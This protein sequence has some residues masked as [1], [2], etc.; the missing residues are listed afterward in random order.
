MKH[1]TTI[2]VVQSVLQRIELQQPLQRL[3]VQR[4]NLPNTHFYTIPSLS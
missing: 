4:G 2:K 3:I 1:E